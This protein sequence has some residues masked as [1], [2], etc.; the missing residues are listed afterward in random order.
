MSNEPDVPVVPP[1]PQGATKTSG[2]EWFTD[3]TKI[4]TGKIW[5]SI[6]TQTA[7]TLE[8]THNGTNYCNGKTFAAGDCAVL[9]DIIGAGETFNLRQ[10]S[11]STVTLNWCN[12]WQ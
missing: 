12:V 1:V 8:V 6:G 10:S 2:T 11:G 9:V 5:I 7:M 3:T 4:G